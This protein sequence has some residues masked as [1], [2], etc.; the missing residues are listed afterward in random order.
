MRGD[1]AQQNGYDRQVFA[2]EEQDV[3]SPHTLI[4]SALQR[5][6]MCFQKFNFI[7]RS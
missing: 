4:C 5:S 2:P 1:P 6:A 7:F 3:Y